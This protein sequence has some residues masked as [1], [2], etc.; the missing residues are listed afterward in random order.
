MAAGPNNVLIPQGIQHVLI[1][2]QLYPII[3]TANGTHLLI[4][5][6]VGQVQQAGG[7]QV[8][9]AQPIQLG[10]MPPGQAL[11]AT[12]TSQQQQ[13][14]LQSGV[15]IP[16]TMA[17]TNMPHTN[18]KF[19]QLQAV[20]HPQS[21]PPVSAVPVGV[22]QPPI[23]PPNSNFGAMQV[24]NVAMPLQPQPN[25]MSLPSMVP[26]TNGPFLSS[27]Q[28]L[29]SLPSTSAAMVQ[30]PQ[31][32]LMSFPSGNTQVTVTPQTQQLLNKINEQI[33]ILKRKQDLDA[34]GKKALSSLLQAQQHVMS[35]VRQQF[36]MYAQRAA[37]GT[38]P[39]LPNPQQQAFGGQMQPAGA[40]SVPAPLQPPG[41]PV[42]PANT[43]QPGMMQAPQMLQP[44]LAQLS[45]SADTSKKIVEPG[46]CIHGYGY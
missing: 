18:Q 32:P 26:V 45:A 12:M 23:Q 14:P 13:V 29:N 43:A 30:T 44:G 2:G 24:A 11:P 33:E 34:Q 42:P 4:Q 31:T 3:Q 10:S 41:P 1:N 9:T 46:L 5:Q 6:P 19:N 37:P 7:K 40:A 36:Q 17:Q 15:P 35:N 22:S 28:K 27:Q 39:R 21:M 16:S 8:F 20:S 38:Q 25:N